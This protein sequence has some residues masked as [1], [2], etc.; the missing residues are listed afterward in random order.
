MRQIESP[1]LVVR[2]FHVF[3]GKVEAVRG[4]SLALRHGEITAVI[5]PNGAGKSSLL[6]A[7]MGLL[8][9]S[10]SVDLQGAEIA[11]LD[12]ARRVRAGLSLVPELRELFTSMTVGDNLDLGAFPHRS[13]KAGNARRLDE[14]FGLFPR[15]A[16]RRD[17]K[18]ST[19]SGGERQMLALGRALMSRPNMLLL[20][21]PSLGLS[22]LMVIEVFKSLLRLRDLGTTVL[23]VE[24]NARAALA[25]A[26]YGYVI[27]QGTI[28]MEGV[29]TV[30][31]SD[32]KIAR[33]YLGGRSA[34]HGA[35]EGTPLITRSTADP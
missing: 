4:V 2:D 28:V 16:E 24:Q 21:E 30:L 3:Y 23:L 17:Q 8:P 9:C 34:A 12:A 11:G 22:P 26:E 35:D 7:V 19:L 10:G 33:S 1:G 20:D 31:E 14:V 25:I 6:N 29:S 5:G 15:L 18:A 32:P 13:D 27:E